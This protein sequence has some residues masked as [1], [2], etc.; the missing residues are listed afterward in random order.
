MKKGFTLIELLVVLAIIGILA[1][2]IIASLS[3]ARARARDAQRK[4]DL[5]QIKSALEQYF[6][7]HNQQYP[8]DLSELTSGTPPYIKAVPTD[9]STGASYSYTVVNS[10]EG[11]V[12]GSAPCYS[13]SANL[14]NNNEAV[15]AGVTAGPGGGNGVYDAGGGDKYFQV[16]ND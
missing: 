6:Q 13:V 10:G 15:T 1:A 7:D 14:E 5:R 16:S 9:P 2:M 3:G 12:S 8:S 4:S 11:C